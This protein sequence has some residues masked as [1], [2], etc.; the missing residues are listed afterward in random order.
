MNRIICAAL[1]STLF[2]FGSVAY[3]HDLNANCSF[4]PTIKY[5]DFYL[6]VMTTASV[7]VAH[8]EYAKSV[9]IQVRDEDGTIMFGGSLNIHAYPGEIGSGY[10][11]FQ[12]QKPFFPENTTED[13]KK[14]I[15]DN[16]SSEYIGRLSKASCEALA[17]SR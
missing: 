15:L 9:N 8:S 5:G 11:Y 12:D 7:R 13:Q 2:L 10:T 1:L 4:T 3:A 16:F 6:Q 17:F 14:I